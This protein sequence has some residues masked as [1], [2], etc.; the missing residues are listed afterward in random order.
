MSGLT[1]PLGV[2]LQTSLADRHITR[3]VRDVWFRHTTPG[4]FG[5]C[6]VSLHRPIDVHQWD[7]TRYGRLYV[8]DTRNGAA[9]WEGRI[10]DLGRSA[11]NDGAIWEIGA[12]GPMAYASDRTIPLIYVDSAI[13]SSAWKRVDDATPGGTADTR[14]DPSTLTGSADTQALVFQFPDGLHLVTDSRVTLRYARLQDTGQKLARYDYIDDEGRTS[15]DLTIEGV[16]R[17]DGSLAGGEISRTNTFSTSGHGSA[18]KSITANFPVGRNTLDVRIRWNGGSA[19]VAD[20]V[21]WAAVRSVSIQATRYDSDG[22]ELTS[23]IYLSVVADSLIVNDLLGRLLLGHF[24]GVTV[25]TG[26]HD[27]DQLAYPDGTTAAGVLADLMALNAS[28]GHNMAWLVYD[29][30]D[31]QG[32]ARLR[33]TL[34]GKYGFSWRAAPTDV[35]YQAPVRH[36][37]DIPES[38]ADLYNAVSVRWVDAAGYTKH[39]RRTQTVAELDAAGITREA[40]LDLDTELGSQVA[41]ERAGD[42]FLAAHGRALAAGRLTIR[43][44]VTSTRSTTYG[45]GTLQPWQARPWE[46]IRLTGLAEQGD[47]QSQPTVPDGVTTFFVVA[48]EYRASTNTMEL[49]LDKHAFTT[50]EAMARTFASRGKRPTVDRLVSRR[51]VQF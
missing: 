3:Y 14:G 22:N 51:R 5:A 17:T 38:A 33:S 13:D 19:Q 44:P 41:A 36:G 8:Y 48:C 50:V 6:Q 27:V 23:G 35:G 29:Q 34:D 46:I 21:T 24:E 40:Y 16:T 12:V 2:R 39:T 25:D 10:E 37:L 31:A 7:I 45:T 28:A 11:G 43:G 30:V 1:V 26:T 20:D 4:G 9:V 15:T 18:S 47:L 42:E 32:N 49:E